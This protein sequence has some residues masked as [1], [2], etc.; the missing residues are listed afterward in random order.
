[1][2]KITRYLPTILIIAAGVGIVLTAKTAI[3]AHEKCMVEKEALIGVKEGHDEAVKEAQKNAVKHYI[4]PV[5]IG[6]ATFGCI[7]GIRVID[8]RTQKNLLAAAVYS[9][10]LLNKYEAKTIEKLGPEEAAKIKEEAVGELSAGLCE[11]IH[12]SYS[13]PK[14]RMNCYDPYTDTFFKASQTELLL[15][16]GEINKCIANGGG[17]SV[18]DFHKFFGK[19]ISNK[20]PDDPAEIPGWYCDDDFSWNSSFYGNYVTLL[21]LITCVKGGKDVLVVNVSHEPRIP[22]EDFL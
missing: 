8:I 15:I 11:D 19:D 22:S 6:L 2:I 10:S 18:I 12:Q 16:E 4:L 13:S 1:M 5:S 20:Y 14:H 7:L 3:D 21:P 9:E 17:M